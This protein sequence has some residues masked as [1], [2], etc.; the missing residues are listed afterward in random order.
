[1]TRATNEE[2]RRMRLDNALV[3]RGLASSRARAPVWMYSFDWE[4]PAFGGRL[5]S[6]HSID[7]PFVFDTLQVIGRAH[8]TP[9]AQTLADRV[10]RTWAAFAR[11][12]NP[13]N[14]SIPAWPAYTAER[15]AT[16]R[17]DD[18]CHVVDDPDGE[19]RPLWRKVATA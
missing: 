18:D 13:A 10:S 11:N 2:T 3:A 15:R 6:P 12:G 1:M 14:P 9:H 17:F 5:K 19:V 16:M 7:V 8:H 4:T